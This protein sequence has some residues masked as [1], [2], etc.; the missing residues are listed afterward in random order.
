MARKITQ[1]SPSLTPTLG[2]KICGRDKKSQWQ[3]IHLK[4]GFNWENSQIALTISAVLSLQMSRHHRLRR[5][6]PSSSHRRCSAAVL[7]FLLLLHLVAESSG[8]QDRNNRR[9]RRRHNNNGG[10]VERSLPL[11]HLE[12][13][14]RRYNQVNKQG[15]RH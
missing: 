3:E 11:W 12:R 4:S 15:L 5:I 2:N 13:S 10:S 14:R 8:L 6:S 9:R 1:L 7:L